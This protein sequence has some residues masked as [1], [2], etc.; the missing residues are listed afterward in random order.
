MKRLLAT[1][2]MRRLDAD[3]E[4]MFGPKLLPDIPKPIDPVEAA[5]IDARLYEKAQTYPAL[6]RNAA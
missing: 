5:A 6:R 1:D 4:A 3:F 2:V